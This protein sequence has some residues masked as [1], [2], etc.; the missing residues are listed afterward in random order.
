MR[1]IGRARAADFE[2]TR[3]DQ[4][5]WAGSHHGPGNRKNGNGGAG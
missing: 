1:K 5:E 3:D 2:L 4:Y